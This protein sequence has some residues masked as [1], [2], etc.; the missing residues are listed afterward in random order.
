M[1]V[2]VRNNQLDH[3]SFIYERDVNIA[4]SYMVRTRKNRER[5]RE[6]SDGIKEKLPKMTNLPFNARDLRVKTCNFICDSIFQ[7]TSL[8]RI[9]NGNLNL[10]HV[11]A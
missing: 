10:N 6:Q 1:F 9:F 5:E 4:F 7:N 11:V 8:L 2:A 3:K